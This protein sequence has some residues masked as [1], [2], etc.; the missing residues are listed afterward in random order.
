MKSIKRENRLRLRGALLRVNK[1]GLN[2]KVR[3]FIFG[4]LLISMFAGFYYFLVVKE[5]EHAFDTKRFRSLQTLSENLVDRYIE[6]LEIQNDELDSLPQLANND[7][8]KET[9][10]IEKSLMI[11]LEDGKMRY[12]PFD[13]LFESILPS[14][15][16]E[17]FVV[18]HEDEV[19]YE[20]LEN[21]LRNT[22][23][24]SIAYGLNLPTIG[25]VEIAGKDSRYYTHAFDFSKAEKIIINKAKK[26]KLDSLQRQELHLRTAD[27]N[28]RWT[29]IGFVS[30]SSFQKEITQTDIWIVIILTI[31]IFIV[32]A[33]LPILK[34]LFVG[35][36]ELI[37]AKDA[38]LSLLS[39]I[40]G[41]PLIAT[42]IMALFLYSDR[43]YVKV[44]EDLQD[45]N[46]AIENQFT[47]E[48]RSMIS[49][50]S[51]LDNIFEE[52]I[53]VD[54]SKNLI[55]KEVLSRKTTQWY[56]TAKGSDTQFSRQP[57]YYGLNEATLLYV[58]EKPASKDDSVR[59]KI[60]RP[61]DSDSLN[62]GSQIIQYPVPVKH[63][64][65][66]L[67]SREYFKNVTAQKLWD[68]NDRDIY[69]E[70][71]VSWYTGKREAVL[72][73]WSAASQ[74]QKNAKRVLA[75]SATMSSIFNTILPQDFQFAIIN[76][77]GKVL[78]HSL[79]KRNNNENFFEE[80]DAN[81]RIKLNA[82]IELYQPS[83]FVTSYWGQRVYV[84]AK[85][86]DSLPLTLITYYPQEQTRIYISEVMSTTLTF[87]LMSV[88]FV[89]FLMWLT[90]A[91]NR[92][93]NTLS[94]IRPLVFNWLR[95]NE[96]YALRYV[97]LI[98]F[99]SLTT[100]PL[101]LVALS[102][103]PLFPK[104]YAILILIP[105]FNFIFLYCVLDRERKEAFRVNLIIF[106]LIS[107]LMAYLFEAKLEV[108]LLLI[109]LFAL[110]LILRMITGQNTGP[111]VT[112]LNRRLFQFLKGFRF[113]Y[114]WLVANRTVAER[115]THEV[116]EYKDKSSFK[117]LWRNS[118][119]FVSLYKT[120]MFTWIVSSFLIPV[121]LIFFQANS[122]ESIL[123][124]KQEMHSYI[125][126]HEQKLNTLLE[127]FSKED[128][129][130]EYIKPAQDK[131][132]F[133]S[134]FE[135][136]DYVK[137]IRDEANE[138][139][140]WKVS[141]EVYDHFPEN[142]ES[143][144]TKFRKAIRPLLGTGSSHRASFFA[145]SH[146]GIPLA[147]ST[148][149]DHPLR[150]TL[151]NKIVQPLAQM[152]GLENY[153]YTHLYAPFSSKPLDNLI[154]WIV[155]PATIIFLLALW[156]LVGVVIK[157]L[158][159]FKFG[160]IKNEELIDHAREMISLN[161]PNWCTYLIVTPSTKQN[162]EVYLDEDLTWLLE[163]N[164]SLNK[165]SNWL[166]DYNSAPMPKAVDTHWLKISMSEDE[167]VRLVKT[168]LNN[169]KYGIHTVI[170]SHYYPSYILKYLSQLFY[171]KEEIRFVHELQR[172]LATV[173]QCVLGF[174]HMK[175]GGTDEL[176][177]V[178]TD[179]IA[180]HKPNEVLDEKNL[181]EKEIKTIENEGLLYSYYNY[182]WSTLT[183]REK[184][185]L[186]DI[187]IDGF[188]NIKSVRAIK[189]LLYKGL[190]KWKDRS[191]LI[192]FT[193][194]FRSFILNSIAKNYGKQIEKDIGKQ[195]T[196][197]SLSIV[198]YIMVLAALIFV[199][200][201]EPDFFRDF[202]AFI[203]VVGA[204]ITIFPTLSSLVFN[205]DDRFE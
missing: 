40:I 178:M 115:I 99:L 144:E 88:V 81:D 82:H 10:V 157:S 75:M 118:R 188:L 133:Q 51:A 63:K 37:K 110:T 196:W 138:G 86:I 168:M 143:V 108:G 35:E 135:N 142:E 140:E 159:G 134:K 20:N 120:C 169:E 151:Q 16:F 57:Y 165:N 176:R 68:F 23:L 174:N 58:A 183:D 90:G 27:I 97:F 113:S 105:A 164:K 114:I 22:N 31:I 8:L 182:L 152:A 106:V 201:S 74:E 155:F 71:V 2:P 53:E 13:V 84:N 147:W 67:G 1:D 102:E 98:I 111:L 162:N 66:E 137:V 45:L 38:L 180:L 50:L 61:G 153:Q 54:A 94:K 78:F 41:V 96:Q 122:E 7:R 73:M 204:I 48:L 191:R 70:S 91:I 198:I 79:E 139:E 32:L 163:G 150:F 123:W 160:E 42:V 170:I 197:A 104:S 25:K 29:I 21:G 11:K 127:D 19:I 190:L 181:L 177:S 52:M 64:Y 166:L 34:L 107:L 100:I 77:D 161:R 187:S 186:Y 56:R 148:E 103:K 65:L 44:K 28:E 119:A 33:C 117:N 184:Y 171:E 167:A 43:H 129:K 158:F 130:F 175:N 17:E 189:N 12:L 149:V 173:P 136:G 116:G 132:F 205:T 154:L 202:D 145:K 55:V 85:P 4:I 192:I 146:D 36:V 14:A 39:I 24:D 49:E 30:K 47:G 179:E 193:R 141:N 83:T 95:P 109:C 203:T 9:G 3:G 185:V 72:S 59:V 87:F 26:G 172:L 101:L 126:S 46:Q 131:L 195:S 89:V 18:L 6:F 15:I 69:L 80:I 124:H 93:H 121:V 199:A 128:E 76:N 156:F 62:N 5:K 125:K 112:E 60:I 200:L 92:R 194:S